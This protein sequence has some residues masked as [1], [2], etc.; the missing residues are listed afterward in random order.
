MRKIKIDMYIDLSL[1]ALKRNKKISEILTTLLKK[2][3]G[4]LSLICIFSLIILGCYNNDKLE[5][6]KANIISPKQRYVKILEGEK[7]YFQSSVSGGFPPYTYS[8]DFGIVAPSSTKKNPREIVFNWQGTYEVML[9]VK[10]KRNNKSTDIVKII[11]EK[12]DLL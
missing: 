4:Y 2:I 5:E 7:Q 8:W 9:T 10:D 1:K 12:D 6:L 11:V 3:F